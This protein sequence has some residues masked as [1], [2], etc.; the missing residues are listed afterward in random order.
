MDEFVNNINQVRA[1]LASYVPGY[2]IVAEPVAT[3]DEEYF[4]W[5]VPNTAKELGCDPDFDGWTFNANPRP[6]PG[7]N[8]IRTGAGHVHIGWTDGADVVDKD[9]FV[10]CARVARQM[11]YYLGIHSLIWDKDDTRRSLYGK[12][13]AFRPKPYGM[14][15]RVLS[16]RWLE[17]EALTRWVY[18]TIQTG[19][20]DAEAGLWAEDRYENLARHII[21]DNV[22]D[23]QEQWPTL[24]LGLEK[25]PA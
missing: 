19:M 8:P 18:N 22:L 7:N 23:W 24:E 2:N 1:T 5:D 9:H 14:E 25:V 16:N 3:Y 6:D 17:S 20:S 11:D 15:Y 13:G 21:N 10:Q 12:A 4:R